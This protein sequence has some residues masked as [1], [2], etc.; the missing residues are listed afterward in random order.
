M[1]LSLPPLDCKLQEGS[2]FCPSHWQH[3]QG[4]P[5]GAG[6]KTGSP[7]LTV[8]LWP[9]RHQLPR[10]VLSPQKLP[11]P[12]WK[13][14]GQGT[15]ATLASPAGPLPGACPQLWVLGKGTMCSHGVIFE[16]SGLWATREASSLQDEP[17]SCPRMHTQHL[18][19]G[20]QQTFSGR[21]HVTQGLDWHLMSS[22]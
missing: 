8:R 3:G 11:F 16:Q 18:P 13:D 17:L 12:A 7:A 20:P 2:V 22:K 14:H 1:L 5:Q 19:G 6:V 15:P 21:I 4:D 10:R 9:P